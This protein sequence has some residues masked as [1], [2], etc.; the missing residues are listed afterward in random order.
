MANS[1]LTWYLLDSRF[2]AQT[3]RYNYMENSKPDKHRKYARKPAPDMALEYERLIA[4][5]QEERARIAQEIHDDISQRIALVGFALARLT[6]RLPDSTEELARGLGDAKKRLME[7]GMDI[8]ALSYRLDPP[9]FD[10]LGLANAAITFCKELSERQG[11]KITCYVGR[12]PRALPRDLSLSI[13]RVLQEALQNAI[14]H[15]GT[16]EF[17][18]QLSIRTNAVELV[19]HDSGHGFDAIKAK[20]QSVNGELSIDA[21]PHGGTSIRARVP[22]GAKRKS[23]ARGG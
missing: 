4:A 8:Q 5:H 22:L 7:I 15:G 18:V 19:V 3:R 12:L 6:Q 21:T 14:K 23:V 2:E 9:R 1:F 20:L 11:V 17:R 13:Y 16:H 10:V